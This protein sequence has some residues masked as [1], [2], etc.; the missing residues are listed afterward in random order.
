MFGAQVTV[1]E[2]TVYVPAIDLKGLHS[3]ALLGVSQLHKA[4][5]SIQVAE[6]SLVVDTV[7]IPDKLWPEP[8]AFVVEEGV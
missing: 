8:A 1:G 7:K 4:K 6:G 2:K 3:D 5:A